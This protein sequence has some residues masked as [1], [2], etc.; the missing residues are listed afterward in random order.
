LN[1]RPQAGAVPARDSG[2][3]LA[4]SDDVDIDDVLAAAWFELDTRLNE[5][6]AATVRSNDFF[7]RVRG[8]TV[9]AEAN[10][11]LPRLF[12]TTYSMRV[13]TSFAISLY[14]DEICLVMASEWCRRMTYFYSCWIEANDVSYVFS[15]EQ[16]S[17][18]DPDPFW[19]DACALMPAGSLAQARAQTVDAM[20]PRD[21]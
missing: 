20:R 9:G 11:G 4:S 13:A 12:C 10:R 6:P 14:T 17:G 18:Y 8:S 19:V 7:I 15:P 21:P 3:G 16:L 5:S 2:D 1:D